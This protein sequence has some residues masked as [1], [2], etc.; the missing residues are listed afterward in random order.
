MKDPIRDILSANAPPDAFSADLHA[1]TLDRLQQARAGAIPLA[2]GVLPR[3]RAG[4]GT[5]VIAL[6]AMVVAGLWLVPRGRQTPME[7]PVALL[8]L[9]EDL[10][11][12]IGPWS[13]FAGRPS[14]M[15]SAQ[16]A[17]L[18]EDAM[19]FGQFLG[20]RLPTLPNPATTN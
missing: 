8:P 2:E 18:H 5:A 12:S 17:L 11:E 7:P 3:R 4:G 20:D 19:R 16:L 15:T 13:D 9:I 14:R 6:A 1:R 10:G